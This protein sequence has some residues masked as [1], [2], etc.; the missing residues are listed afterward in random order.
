[1]VGLQQM[2]EII[3]KTP[4]LVLFMDRRKN[5]PRD[6]DEL[7]SQLI[8]AKSLLASSTSV[9]ERFRL[10]GWIFQLVQL[11]KQCNVQV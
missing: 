8:A 4:M 10:R 11:S 2:R 9:V 3:V 1:M 5:M 7:I 6:K